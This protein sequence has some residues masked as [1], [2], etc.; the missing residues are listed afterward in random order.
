MCSRTWYYLARPEP[1]KSTYG[2]GSADLRLLTEPARQ[3]SKV[4]SYRAALGSGRARS[5]EEQWHRPDRGRSETFPGG[6]TGNALVS[7][8]VSAIV[9]GIISFM[10]THYQAI[11]GQQATAI[12]QLESSATTYYNATI[13]IGDYEYRL[14]TN[15]AVLRDLTTAHTP[16]TSPCS[17][18]MWP[19]FRSESQTARQAARIRNDRHGGI[20]WR[21]LQTRAS[22]DGAIYQ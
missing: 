5:E 8:V 11:S 9:A 16:M 13:A 14:L 17:R 22:A 3:S 1:V 12:T 21:P 10:V 15:P 6:W 7:G 4:R 18:L 20:C 19:T 2:V